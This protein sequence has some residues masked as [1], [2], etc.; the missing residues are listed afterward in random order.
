MS[1]R[2]NKDN[3]DYKNYRDKDNREYKPKLN[4]D[5]NYSISDKKGKIFLYIQNMVQNTKK[6][7]LHLNTQTQVI[8]QTHTN[9]NL[10]Q[11]ITKKIN[12]EIEKDLYQEVLVDRVSQI[13][14]R[15]QDINIKNIIRRG[16]KIKLII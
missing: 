1:Y 8:N 15:D 14:V 4:Y 16:R 13:P 7:I 2:N 9:P 5:K 6:N 11:K 10:K 12:I 3:K